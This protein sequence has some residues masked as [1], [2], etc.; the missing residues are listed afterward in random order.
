MTK[1][2][3]VAEKGEGEVY[4]GVADAPDRF[5][6]YDV[7]RREGGK[8]VSFEEVVSKSPLSVN[9]WNSKVS[10]IKEYDKILFARNL[11]AM[12]SAGL[13]L[14]RALAVIERQTRS[15]KFTA[16]IGEVSSDVR[17]G[18]TLHDALAKSPRVFSKLFVAMVKA[19]EESGDLSGALMMIADQSERV[20]AIKKKIR[21]AMIYPSIIVIAIFG[22]G[23]LMMT[24]VVPT[25][26]Q[27]FTEMHVKLPAST[28][29]VIG[30]S[31]FLV[32]NTVLALGIV[33]AFVAAIYFSLKTAPVKH[34]SEWVVLKIPIIGGIVREVN[35]ARTSRTLAS[36]LAAGVDVLTSL[37]I[38]REV[39]Q[40]SHFRAVIDAAQKGISA[41]EPLSVSFAR[42][43]DLYPAF[44]GEMMAVGEETGETNEMLKR[45]AAFYEEEVDRKTKDMSTII[46]PVLMLLIGAAVGFFAVSMISP[47]Y[48]LSSTIG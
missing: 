20:L 37:Q 21:G 33:V 9:Y 22:I 6:L 19:G 40:N 15:P 7:V 36:L 38:S 14:A 43:E 12:L 34:V 8:I 4:K 28:R 25:L 1:F 31:D 32:G 46:E 26:A 16:I 48:S 45:L 17:R 11:G 30:L 24:F 27:T 10:R 18:S 13:S 29:F 41:G 35:A 5:A 44:V 39:V 23:F 42:H 47:I 3:Y 2:S